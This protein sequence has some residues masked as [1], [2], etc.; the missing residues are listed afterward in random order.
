MNKKQIISRLLLLRNVAP[1]KDKNHTTI[2]LLHILPQ[3]VKVYKTTQIQQ[4][5]RRN[6]RPTTNN[7]SHKPIYI[8]P[9]MFVWIPLPP[10]SLSVCLCI[11][12]KMLDLLLKMQFT[13]GWMSVEYNN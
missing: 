4:K 1:A 10:L 13:I 11:D 2:Y 12:I 3:I 6:L 5:C 9:N 8:S 7:H